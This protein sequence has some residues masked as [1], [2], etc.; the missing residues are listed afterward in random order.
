MKYKI[1]K[2]ELP[3][4]SPSKHSR[5]A[6]LKGFLPTVP[7]IDNATFPIRKIEFQ[8]GEKLRATMKQVLKI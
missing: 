8:Q 1:K 3:T 7:C 4:L 5:A 6:I 2:A